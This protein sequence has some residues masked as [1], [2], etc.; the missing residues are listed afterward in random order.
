MLPLAA[1]A[2]AEMFAAW[3]DADRRR[4]DYGGDARL[5]VAFAAFCDVRADDV[6]GKRTFHERHDTALRPGDARAS[7]RKRRHIESDRLAAPWFPG[8]RRRRLWF[9]FSVVIVH[10]RNIQ[11]CFLHVQMDL[12]T[13]ISFGARSAGDGNI[14]G[15]RLHHLFVFLG[16]VELSKFTV[17]P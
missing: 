5:D 11:T 7:E 16:F 15:V 13:A 4:F 8:R 17:Y 6:A 3:G 12:H 1:A 14:R 2:I 9:M 10:N